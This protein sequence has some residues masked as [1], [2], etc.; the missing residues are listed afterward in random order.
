M[1]ILD[2][3]LDKI[4]KDREIGIKCKDFN[5]LLKCAVDMAEAFTYS[6]LLAE[7]AEYL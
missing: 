5:L 6:R 3:D 4:N 7:E 2:I 1:N